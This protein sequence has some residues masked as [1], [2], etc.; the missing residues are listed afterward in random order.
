MTGFPVVGWYCPAGQQR[1]EEVGFILPQAAVNNSKIGHHSHAVEDGG[2]RGGERS[3]N[4][5]GPPICQVICGKEGISGV[6]RGRKANRSV[7]VG[8]CGEMGGQ[9]KRVLSRD[10]TQ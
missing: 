1:M 4:T 10:H 3:N 2:S 8:V 9:L 6:K 5:C 7:C